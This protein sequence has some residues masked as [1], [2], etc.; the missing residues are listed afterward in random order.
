MQGATSGA[1]AAQPCQPVSPDCQ[2]TP[3]RNCSRISCAAQLHSGRPKHLPCRRPQ[4]PYA[5]HPGAAPRPAEPRL[6]RATSSASAVVLCRFC[7]ACCSRQ[8]SKV[9]SWISRVAPRPA[10]S[11]GTATVKAPSEPHIPVPG[12]RARLVRR[13][14]RL[15]LLAQAGSGPQVRPA[16][17]RCRRFPG[18]HAEPTCTSCCEGWVSPEYTRLQPS[19]CRSTRPYASA[20]SGVLGG[21]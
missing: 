3:G 2:R 18:V 11:G 4:R 6:T 14:L 7:R 5:A 16:K 12:W 1:A 15:A 13:A 9:A 20:M 19:S 10:C 17:D 8:G 21:G